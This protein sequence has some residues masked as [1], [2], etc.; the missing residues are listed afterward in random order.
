M[1]NTNYLWLTTRGERITPGERCL[2]Y[3]VAAEIAKRFERPIVVNIGVS[4]GASVHCLYAGAPGARLVAIDKDFASRPVQSVYALSGVEFVETFS[5]VYG[6]SFEEPV[7]LLF[8]DG[9]HEY[10]TIKADIDAWIPHIPTGGLAIF[11]DYAPSPRDRDRLAGV[12]RAVDEWHG[13]NLFCWLQVVK[14]D[15]VTVF[16]RVE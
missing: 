8:V 2:L 5:N 6:R 1:S 11:H 3:A 13:A 15:S 14:V 10:E 7:H 16:E 9:G 12:E 4:W